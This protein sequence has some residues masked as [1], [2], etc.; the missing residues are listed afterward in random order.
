MVMPS[1]PK[2]SDV[3]SV[4]LADPT[5]HRALRRMIATKMS[6]ADAE[7]VLQATLTDAVAAAEA[8]QSAHEIRKWVFGIARHKIA[9]HHRRAGRYELSESVPEAEATSAP[10][11]A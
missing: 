6:A 10:H 4:T 2:N 1:S 3:R 8:P 11:S 5:L 7:D 9:D